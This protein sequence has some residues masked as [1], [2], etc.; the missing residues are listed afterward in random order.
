[1]DDCIFCKIAN[2]EIP[3]IKIWEDEK[4]VAILDMNPN[5]K[6]MTL[7]MTKAHYDSYAFDMHDMEYI[8]LMVASKTVAKLLEKGLGVKR[9]AMVMEGMGVNHVHIKLYPMYGLD[10]KFTETW[11]PERMFFDKY[12]GYIT[13]HLGPKSSAEELQKV[14]DEIRENANLD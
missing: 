2:S 8:D 4:H 13:T 11:T 6:G 10:E 9:V 12:P 3:S 14:A 5:T 1:M 7:V